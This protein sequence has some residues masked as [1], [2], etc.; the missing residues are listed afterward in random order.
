M[1]DA[2]YFG[3]VGRLGPG[4]T[5]ER[6][7]REMDAI[8][9]R[10]RQ[11]H[12][13]T[14]R[15]A[16]VVVVGL[17]DETTRAASGLVW[18]LFAISG[19]VL[20]I[21][22][23]NVATLFLASGLERR[24]DL[25]IR[26]ALGASRARLA[27]ELSLESLLLA[28]GGGALGVAIAWI[29]APAAVRLLPAGLPRTSA[30]DFDPTAV[31]LFS[32]LTATVTALLAGV[33]PA[34]LAARAA[35][36]SLRDGGRSGPSR[37]TSRVAGA[38][39]TAQLAIT[40]VLVTSTGLLL[41]A[42][43]ELHA[44]DVGIDIERLLAVS[45]SLPDAR[46]R[47]RGAALDVARMTERLSSLPGVEAAAAVQTLPLTGPGPSAGLRVAGRSYAPG[48]APDV[49]WTAV[50]PGYFRTVGLPVLRGREFM[51]ADGEE[52]MSV[53][54]VNE[55]LAA[56]VRPG[57]NPVGDS[58]GTGLDGEGARVRIVGVVADAPQ[59]GLGGV[60][61]PQM[62]RPIAQ[63]SRVG[64]ESMAFVVRTAGDPASLT[65][66]ARQAIREVHPGAPVAAVRPLAAV[67]TA[68][69]AR[70]RSAAG[71]LAF[72]GAIA[73]GLAAVGLYGV[74]ARVVA[75]RRRELGVRL[76][77]GATPGAVRRLVLGRTI[78]MAG[79]GLL[80]GSAGSLAAAR[81]LET[82]LHGVSPSD[83]AVLSAA[84][85]VLLATMLAAAYAPARRA[86]RIDPLVVLKE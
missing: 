6:V 11:A 81:Q 29:A 69:I 1:R 41:R 82:L 68:G 48:E 85:L 32:C 13:D 30:P 58:I 12:P 73:L 84:A 64:L 36:G 18:G 75:D 79:A 78:V 2:H 15:T 51:P 77:L 65:M 19:G 22:C 76:A 34:L 39:V 66:A 70:E 72:F 74:M 52:S 59:D 5:L 35:P 54:V 62:Y 50:T 43:W 60:P 53:A 80:I 14:N 33:A 67:A 17:H 46:S 8:A 86:S 23:A 16:G 27:G 56:L 38:M 10:L 57:G 28:L 26:S 21:A 7:Q 37:A 40:L 45:V 44:R 25:A 47:G 31:V 61:L 55:A 49:L 83:P 71:A 24:R 20:L 3:V 9:A 42:V 63:P 4:V